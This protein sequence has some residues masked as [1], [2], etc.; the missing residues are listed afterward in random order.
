MRVDWRCC[1]RS[2]ARALVF[3]CEAALSI[4]DLGH[5]R[6]VT[7]AAVLPHK[8]MRSGA[9]KNVLQSVF[10][11]GRPAST[12]PFSVVRGVAGWGKT[13][14]AV[15][16]RYTTYVPPLPLKIHSQPVLKKLVSLDSATFFHCL[17]LCKRVSGPVAPVASLQT[18]V[19]N[20][21]RLCESLTFAA[22]HC[23]ALS[24]KDLGH[25]SEV[26]FLNEK[27]RSQLVLAFGF[28]LAN[29]ASTGPF[30]S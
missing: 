6:E 5:A 22:L 14:K 29:L 18:G 1:S 30:S 23:V 13:H 11:A 9:L 21:F 17:V 24:I 2:A 28:G 27:Q 15:D 7:L 12:G 26:T 4:K 3:S 10:S 8:I 25:A 19:I 16:L 20:Q